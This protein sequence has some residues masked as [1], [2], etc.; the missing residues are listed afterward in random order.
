V[1]DSV[2]IRTARVGPDAGLGWPV[3]TARSLQLHI[4]RY[5]ATSFLRH[6]GRKRVDF[7]SVL[8]SVHDQLTR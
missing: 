6:L 3:V 5:G 1:C 4:R 2:P 8:G 7:A